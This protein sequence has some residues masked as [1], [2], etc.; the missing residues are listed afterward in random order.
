MHQSRVLLSVAVA[1]A[2][3]ATVLTAGSGAA[4]EGHAPRQA[5]KAGKPY[6]VTAKADR[7]ELVLGQK[8][9]IK[10]K[11]SP[12]AAGKTVLLQQKI[13]DNPWKDQKTATIKK[14]GRYQVSDKP[15]T[16]NARKYRV[17][18]AA[19]NK[20]R[21]GISKPIAVGVYQWHDVYDLQERASD[22]MYQARTVDINTVEFPKSLVGYVYDNDEDPTGFIDYNLERQCTTLKATYGMSDDADTGSSAKIDVVGDGTQ[23]YTGTF[24][25]LESQARTID[26]RGVFRLA[27]QFQSLTTEHP[28]PAVGSPRVLCSF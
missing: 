7:A 15:T 23:L 2:L 11:V 9:T 27:F 8:V 19:S 26:I 4:A 25:L 16:M 17:V 20:H 18:K 6:T 22:S 21:K 28:R 24:A 13:D 5:N 12:A 3:G 1:A 10:G 14:S